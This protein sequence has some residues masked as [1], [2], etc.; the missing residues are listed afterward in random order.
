MTSSGRAI[1]ALSPQRAPLS[2]IHTQTSRPVPYRGL[3]DALRRIAMEEGVRGLMRGSLARLV[4]H[5]PAAA[6]SWTTYEAAKSVL[7]K[8]H[9]QQ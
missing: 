9:H 6:I 3:G 7:L 5:V 2:A 1:S 4:V 8:V